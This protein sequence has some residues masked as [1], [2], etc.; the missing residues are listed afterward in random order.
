MK[1]I[2]CFAL[3]IICLS[4]F[5]SCGAKAP[6]LAELKPEFVALVE[7]SYEVNEMFFG[8][9]LPTYERG[10]DYDKE[11]KLYNNDDNEY[12]YYEY[13]KQD[14]GY[15]FTE[16]IKWKA[17]EVYT[18]E[19]LSGIYTM[20]FDGYADENTGK[21]TTARYLDSSG[22]LMRY[23][24]GENDPFDKLAGKKRRFDFDS[25]AVVKPYSS[26]YV[27][28]SIDS[29]LDGAEDERLNITLHFKKTSEGWRLDAPT[30]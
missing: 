18:A 2:I 23:A 5:V 14:T 12:A 29:Y 8:E 17:E 3:V 21:V 7:A 16:Q 27:N 25:M 15:Y 28:V 9:G 4:A 30:Y 6:N 13:V 1:K 26:G 20:A 19:Y 11:Y 22:W 24:F 10:G